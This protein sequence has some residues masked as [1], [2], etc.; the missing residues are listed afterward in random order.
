V[1]SSQPSAGPDLAA[2]PDPALDARRAGRSRHRRGAPSAAAYWRGGPELR[3]DLRSSLGIVLAL[4]GAG[5]PAGL[6]WW[7]LAPRADFRI[8]DTGP[9]VIGNPSGELR[10]ADDAVFVLVLAVV[11]LLAGAAAWFLRRRRGVATVVA[12]ALGASVTGAVA[13]QVGE[14]LGAGPTEARLADVG[15]RV[16]TSLE[17]GSLAALAVAP[18]MALVVYMAAVLY[19]RDDD[20]GR[21]EPGAAPVPGEHVPS[22]GIPE[23]AERL[24]VDVPPPGRPAA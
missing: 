8:T 9:V 3:A 19:A 23:P 15:A 11:G 16:T 2:G 6:V 14:L 12:L 4:A 18:F 7:W 22:G 17:L 24:L 13:W 10:A 20:L 1:N 5:L 21:V